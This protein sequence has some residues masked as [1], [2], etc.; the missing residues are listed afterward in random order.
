MNKVFRYLIAGSLLGNIRKK[1]IKIRMKLDYLMGI[2]ARKIVFSNNKVANNK[3]F[4]MS[5]DF[6]FSCNPAA[7]AK[8]LLRRKLPVE[9]YWVIQ[10]KSNREE[11]PPEINLIPYRSY[12]MKIFMFPVF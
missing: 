7:I 8:E 11:F 6:Q 12:T 10:K 2:L 4:I 5:F 9:I 1:L 3:V